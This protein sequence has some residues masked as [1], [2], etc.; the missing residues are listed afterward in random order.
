MP[1]MVFRV[2]SSISSATT[3]L[4]V[5]LS[6]STL[7]AIQAIEGE[8][9]IRIETSQTNGHAIVEVGDTGRGISE[10]ILGRVFDPGFTVKGA[11]VRLGMGLAICSRI[12]QEHGGT[13]QIKSE[14]DRGTTV[15]VSLPI[16]RPVGETHSMFNG[17][18]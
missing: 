9:E 12:V 4:P 11:R 5:I 10:A 18:S 6:I 15:R 16:D 13:I 3:E 17:Q 1:I 7:N 14:V 8:G 2:D